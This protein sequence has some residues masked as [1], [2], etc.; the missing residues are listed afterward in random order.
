M[1]YDSIAKE[2]AWQIFSRGASLE[3]TR[4]EMA[5]DYAGISIRTIEKWSVD[6]EWKERREGADAKFRG[7]VDKLGDGRGLALL[8]LMDLEDV[9]AK[10]IGNLKKSDDS[11]AQQIYALNSTTKQM[12]DLLERFIKASA[13]KV[14]IA[15]LKSAIEMFLHGMRE[16]DGGNQLVT[17]YAARIGQIV[18]AVVEKHGK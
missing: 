8:M 18:T 3:R 11:D 15:V 10:H 14:A 17:K 2:K 16:I 13:D 1:P 4:V 7:F 6:G 5:K 12:A 9:R